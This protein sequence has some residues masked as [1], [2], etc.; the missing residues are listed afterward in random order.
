MTEKMKWLLSG[1]CTEACTSPPVCPYYW[2]S[3]TP[4]ELHG[5]KNQCEGVF[6]FNIKSGYYEDVDLSGLKAAYA[7]NTAEGGTASKEPWKAIVYIAADA[8]EM[9]TRALQDILTQCWRMGDVLGSKKIPGSFIKEKIGSKT[10][11][12]YKHSVEWNG[13]YILKAEP[14]L[15]PDGRPRYISSMANGKIYIGKST[16]NKLNEPDLPRGK[17]DSPGMSNTYYKFTLSPSRLSW[18]P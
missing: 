9:Q 18:M 11:P 12:G 16:E 3:S 10:N 1:D 6:T 5:G 15:T 13:R 17:W 7:F 8:N 4:R 14:L 2:G